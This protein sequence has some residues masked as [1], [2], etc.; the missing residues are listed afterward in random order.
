MADGARSDI[1]QELLAAGELPAIEERIVGPGSMVDATTVFPSTTGPAYLPFLTGC[2]PG[3]AD[4]PG[5][6]WFDRQAWASPNGRPPYRSYVGLESYR[7]NFDIPKS[8]PTLFEMSKKSHNIYSWTCRGAGWRSFRTHLSR[9]PL[10]LWAHETHRWEPIHLYARSHLV[11]AA[12][13]DYDFIFCLIPDIDTFTHLHHPRH[14]KVLGAYRRLDE[15]V[16]QMFDSL[17]RQSRTDSTSVLI[18]SDHGLTA[19]HTHFDTHRFLE[20]RGFSV[21]HYPKIW[22][23]DV[24]AAVMVSG[25]GMAHLYFKPDKT[26]AQL[27]YDQL[28]V[29][30]YGWVLND[31]LADQSVD[32]VIT[33]DETGT[34]HIR[35]N[36]G[37]STVRESGDGRMSYAVVDG[38]DPF[39][40]QGLEGEFTPNE[41]LARTIDTGYPDAPVQLLG[42]VR[43]PRSGDVILSART[44]YDLRARFETQ[45][46]RSTHGALCRE[47][48]LVPL[49]ANRTL[50]SMPT[51]TADVFAMVCRSLGLELPVGVDA[52]DLSI[53]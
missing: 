44:G 23:R 53:V 48:M 40:Y 22:R 43:S 35:G 13:A 50:P 52:R 51:R 34:V 24:N 8:H 10:F 9:S 41:M 47:H 7:F 5:I 11:R 29:S 46:H 14:K 12:A 18:V 30:K 25:N 15:T 19:T 16:R 49:L 1:M 27:C 39:G 45:E 42:L 26:W 20:E 36:G 3:T 2:F 28:F 17:D 38:V 37:H 21:F 31:L 6:R 32:H 4:L 33:R